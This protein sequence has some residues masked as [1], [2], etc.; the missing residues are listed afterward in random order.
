MLTVSQLVRKFPEHFETELLLTGRQEHFTFLQKCK[1]IIY[2]FTFYVIRFQ[3]DRKNF[4]T[5]MVYNINIY[6][7]ST[8]NTHM[9]THFGI[10]AECITWTQNGFSIR[11]ML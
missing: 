6:I 8:L 5:L 4:H 7:R 3:I 9:H 10:Q 1:K 11:C 2:K